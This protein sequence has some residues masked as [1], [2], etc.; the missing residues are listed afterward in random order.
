[1]VFTLPHFPWLKVCDSSVGENTTLPN[2][3]WGKL[4]GL[5]KLMHTL[6]ALEGEACSDIKR[7]GRTCSPIRL[8]LMMF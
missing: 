1:M 7:V 3:K 5:E 6:N 2:L 8:R 4:K